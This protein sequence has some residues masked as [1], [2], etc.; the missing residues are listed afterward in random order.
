[1]IVRTL[2]DKKEF[3]PDY[4]FE[5]SVD[6]KGALTGLFWADEECKRNYMAFGDVISFDATFNTN[7]NKM[8]FVPF[9]GIDNHYRN[10]SVGAGLLASETIESSKWLLNQFL[11]S[12]GSQPKVVVTDQDPAMKQAI[13]Q[14]FTESSHRLCMWHIMKKVAD[15]AGSLS[16]FFL[17]RNSRLCVVIATFL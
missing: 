9:T 12:F 4:S 1:M 17:L 16:L 5:F 14:V 2:S 10:V 3:L 8:D 6:E 7:K 11:K 13:E 15:K